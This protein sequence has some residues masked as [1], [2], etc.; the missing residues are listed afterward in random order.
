MKPKSSVQKRFILAESDGLV[1]ETIQT[2][3]KERD[4]LRSSLTEGDTLRSR[5]SP[6]NSPRQ[7]LRLLKLKGTWHANK[8]NE[9]V[10]EAAGHKVKPEKF[11]L[12]GSWKL[13][14]NQQIE[15]TAADGRDTLIFKGFWKMPSFNKLVYVLEGSSTS[16]FEFKA[17]IESASM[18]PKKGV[19][20]YRI[21]IGARKSR[22]TAPGQLLIIE[23]EWKFGRNLGVNFNVDYG[24]GKIRGVGFGA[25]V[26]F[27]RNI[28]NLSLKSE[29]GKPLGVTLLLTHKLFKKLDAKTF[30]K[31]QKLHKEHAIESGFSIPF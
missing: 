14:K 26:T 12:K 30:L 9:L 24:R 17:N 20:R 21:G 2:Y 18:R 7:E 13:N 1:L 29:S 5:V 6:N 19:V 25:E 3:N 16:R 11:T 10:F 28:V 22:K 23:G 15:Y 27:D 31:L 4:T 8:Y